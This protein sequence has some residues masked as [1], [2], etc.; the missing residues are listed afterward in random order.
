[1]PSHRVRPVRLADFG[2]VAV[3]RDAE[4]LAGCLEDA[5]HYPG[6]HAAGVAHPR[7]DL[8]LAALVRRARR[9][10]PVGA[11]SSLTGGATPMGEIVVTTRRLDRILRVG[12]GEI[13]VQAGVP[14][15]ALR[16]TLARRNAYYPPAPTFEGACAGGV[17]ATNAAGAATFKYGTTRRWIRGLKVVLADGCL[18]D[19]RRGDYRAHPDGYF[20]LHAPDGVRRIPI[21][22]YRMPAVP[23]VSAGYF[24]EPEMDLVDL[25]VGSE[26]TLGIITE[27]T[28]GLV[29]PRP[30]I[31][32]VWLPLPAE[33][34]GLSLVAAL[35]RE[36]EA[37]WRSADPRGLDVSAAEMLDRRSL[38]LLREDGADR[39]H[40]V[41]LPPDAAVALLVQVELPPG[42][43]AAPTA[44]Y[45]QIG[46]AL[47]PAAPD[48]PLV[49]LCR[50][51]ARAGALDRAEI[52]LPGDRRRQAQLFALRE[53]VPEAVNRRVGTAQRT[54]D[55]GIAKTAADMI[56]PF[57]RFADSLRIFR[58]AFERRGLDYAIWGHVSDANVHP[59][60]I[61]RSLR[62]VAAGR[63]AI[64]ECG[65]EV[66]RLGGVPPGGA[67]RGAQPRQAGAAPR[68]VRR[69]RYRADA[70]RQ[71]RAGSGG[72][73]RARRRVPGGD[74]RLSMGV[75]GLQ[76]RPAIAG[77]RP[78]SRPS[79]R[80]GPAFWR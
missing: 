72:Q 62:D 30:E 57:P 38:E 74:R 43:L 70:A 65:R 61:P 52:A 29:S 40:G 76:G 49:R 21:P 12:G 19:F 5:A 67:R 4:T 33:P 18:L 77:S 20:E 59:N 25:F 79:G 28:C 7:S 27:V 11:Q 71:G 9:V 42:A 32:L 2:R 56:V 13:T 51:L 53:A 73:A 8:E 50:L 44:A 3:A 68:A 78:D 22:G 37:T 17:A 34:A 39:V 31:C 16:E 45:E 41:P 35:R 26:G 54:V 47:E 69:R 1:M 10:L 36:A 14:L 15:A 24:A 80:A 58:D 64:L 46:A 75:R 48:T 60:V 6:G 23:K 66:I 55:A 63:E